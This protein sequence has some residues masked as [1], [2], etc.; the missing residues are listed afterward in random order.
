VISINLKLYSILR[1]I[2]PPEANGRAVLEVEDGLS[3]E[4]LLIQ[5]EIRRAVIV[6]IN[7]VHEPNKKY[8]LKDGDDVILFSSVS[9]G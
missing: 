9:G 8:K 1:E 3:I 4:D 2:L 7:G 5:L 6:S